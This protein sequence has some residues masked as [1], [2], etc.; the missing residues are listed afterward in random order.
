M[1]NKIFNIFKKNDGIIIGAIHF[2]PLLGYPD[3][4]G[5]DVTFKNS[6]ADLASFEKGG[7]DAIIIENNYDVPHKITVGPETTASMTYLACKLKEKTKLPI[8]IS[9]LWNDYKAGFAIAK[10]AGLQFI[11][12][13]AF[14]DDVK[15]QYGTVRA[16][17]KEVTEYRKS[18]R[19]DGIGLFAD[20]HVKHSEIISKY[21]LV[22]SARL[23]I[24]YGADAIIVTG[25]WTGD[26]PKIEK[27][28]D[29]RKAVENFPI[30]CGS[31]IDEFNIHNLFSLANGAI[32]STSLKKGQSDSK[33]V[34]V[35]PYTAR[36]NATKVKA[37]VDA[38]EKAPK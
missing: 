12:V 24:Q 36:I 11:R 18:I 38:K 33:D 31:G 8:G 16:N 23:A 22:E 15:T 10:T 14:V 37:L 13:P 32:V 19:A 4:P 25:K 34:N 17:P 20:I 29:V 9:V 27:L 3:F 5:F 28:K 30:L 1:E 2:P 21:T 26:A 6:L 35:K 7:A